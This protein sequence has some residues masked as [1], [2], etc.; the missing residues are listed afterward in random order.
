MKQTVL[1]R[2]INLS[3]IIMKKLMR[4]LLTIRLKPYFFSQ[5]M[6]AGPGAQQH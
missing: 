5:E 4:D 1:L 6:A 2:G 3:V